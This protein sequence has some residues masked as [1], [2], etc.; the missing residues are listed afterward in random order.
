MGAGG[1]IDAYSISGPCCASS[2]LVKNVQT[3]TG[4]QDEENY[5]T[6]RQRDIDSQIAPLRQTIAQSMTTTL[7]SQVKPGETLV[8]S[9]CSPTFTPDHKAG[10][11]AQSVTMTASETCSGLVYNQA[12]LYSTVYTYVH[13]HAP[14]H[15]ILSTVP[16]THILTTMLTPTPAI[17]VAVKGTFVYQF[18]RGELERMKLRIAG[19]EKQQAYQALHSFLGVAAATIDDIST[20]SSVPTDSARVSIRVLVPNP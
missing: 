12:T 9:V 17:T 11:A 7:R 4:G 2:V 1:N 6:V 13:R 8:P 10:D 15:S 5:A 16:M 20:K 18:S 14:A 3:F 19:L